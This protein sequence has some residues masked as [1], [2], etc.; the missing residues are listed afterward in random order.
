MSSKKLSLI[1]LAA[2]SLVLASCVRSASTPPAATATVDLLLPAVTPTFD[3]LAELALGETQTVQAAAGT[4]FPTITPFGGTPVATVGGVQLPSATP[5]VVGSPAVGTPAPTYAYTPVPKPA[6]YTLQTGEFPYCIARRFNVNPSELLSLNG[7]T[8]GG[9]FEPGLTLQIPQ[10]S[11]TFPPPTYLI[12]H[13]ATYTVLSGD[14]IY[15]IACKYGD[16]DPLAIAA[17]NGLQ[18][19]YALTAGQTLQIP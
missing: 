19:P 2:F 3:P 15:G 5:I 18:A 12:P 10:S 13:P 8:D 7:I 16:V 9:L 6:T 14:T 1:A 11:L 4:I 17:A